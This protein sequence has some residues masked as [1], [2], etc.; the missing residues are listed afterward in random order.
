MCFCWEEPNQAQA[1]PGAV[2]GGSEAEA[3]QR[4]RRRGRQGAEGLQ[5]LPDAA[6]PRR[7][8]RAC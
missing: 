6:Q 5:E 8:R 1:D 7:L 4:A 3:G 2:A